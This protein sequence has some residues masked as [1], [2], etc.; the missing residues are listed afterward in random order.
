MTSIQRAHQSIDS[1]KTKGS[2]AFDIFA[3]KEEKG[4]TYRCFWTKN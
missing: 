1:L 3:S 2:E 4:T